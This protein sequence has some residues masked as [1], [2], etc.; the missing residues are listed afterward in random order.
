MGIEQNEFIIIS[1]R[2]GFPTHAV[3]YDIESSTPHESLLT[4]MLHSIPSLK[5]YKGPILTGQQSVITTTQQ[6]IL[7]NLFHMRDWE[8]TIVNTRLWMRSVGATIS[9]IN[10]FT[11][12]LQVL[13]DLPRRQQSD[14]KFV[15]FCDSWTTEFRKVYEDKLKTTVEE[16]QGKMTLVVIR[17]RPGMIL[18]IIIIM[19]INFTIWQ[20]QHE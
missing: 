5:T 13:L 20:G 3:I 9:T 4:E 10:T 19:M 17:F 16:N 2:P 8:H 15:R 1:D 11:D 14:E 6:I 7:P 18:V 12:H